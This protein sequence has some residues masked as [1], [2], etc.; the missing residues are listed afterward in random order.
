MTGEGNFKFEILDFRWRKRQLQR[1]WQVRFQNSG[2]V[3]WTPE[4]G[5]AGGTSGDG[6]VMVDGVVLAARAGL[7]LAPTAE[8]S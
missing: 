6:R 1:R 8:K 7:R 2:G 4:T 5:D 3:H